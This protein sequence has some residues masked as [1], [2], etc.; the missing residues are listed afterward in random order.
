MLN[1]LLLGRTDLKTRQYLRPESLYIVI[2][3]LL[4]IEIFGYMQKDTVQAVKM[5]F[6]ISFKVL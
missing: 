1:V 2:L 6:K 3:I 4:T 5:L